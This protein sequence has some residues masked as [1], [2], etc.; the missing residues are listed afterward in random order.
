MELD[1]KVNKILCDSKDNV[2]AYYNYNVKQS[3]LFVNNKSKMSD[4]E[5]IYHIQKLER[6]KFNF[7][8]Y[9]NIEK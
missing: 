1:L 3:M 7:C 8:G 2:I 5:V 4:D 9:L 6:K